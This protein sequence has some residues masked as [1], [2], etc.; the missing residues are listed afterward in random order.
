[1]S[2]NP[3]LIPV[4]KDAESIRKTVLT[5]VIKM[6]AER[7]YIKK[8]LEKNIQNIEKVKDDDVYQITLDVNMK[9]N[10][11]KQET[12]KFD[13]SVVM[14]KIIHMKIQGIAKISSVKDFINSYKNYHKIFIF[15]SISEK[16]KSSIAE[17]PNTEAFNEVFFMINIVDYIDS[18]KYEL[19]TEEES[20]E[21]IE[22][23]I[24]KKKEMMKMLTSDPIVD[25]FN[26]KR[27][28]IIRII[29]PSEQSGKSIAYRIVAKGAS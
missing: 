15:D 29:R 5:N 4:K 19:L 14:V 7:G 16:A 2:L 17:I 11:N 28:D 24:L 18:P 9:K 13:G 21:V 22:T 12:D 8:S 10:S 26:L 3:A 27:G 20:K 1:M 25:Y 6:I 23:Y